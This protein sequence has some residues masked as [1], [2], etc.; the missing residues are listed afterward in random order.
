MKMKIAGVLVLLAGTA[1][2]FAAT[3]K[4]LN[5]DIK[6][7]VSGVAGIVEGLENEFNL[8]MEL[9]GLKP[10]A[11]YIARLENSTCGDLPDNVAAMPDNLFVATYIESNKFGSYSTVF[12]GLPEYAKNARSVALYSDS[13]S[14]VGAGLENVYCLDLG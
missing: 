12:N 2:V 14:Q 3:H 4:S 10:N 11:Q 1:T 7:G 6:P 9:V 5:T 8:E 13:G